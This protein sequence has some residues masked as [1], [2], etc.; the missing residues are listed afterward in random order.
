[1]E[2]VVKYEV[3]HSEEYILHNTKFNIDFIKLLFQSMHSWLK[4]VI[5][6]MNIHPW[7]TTLCYHKKYRRIQTKK[8][9]CRNRSNNTQWSA[10]MG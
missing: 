4:K 9:M 8:K 6:R 2:E 7:S 10:S 1:M 5:R 3:T